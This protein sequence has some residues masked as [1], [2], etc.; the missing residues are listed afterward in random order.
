M[1]CDTMQ[2]NATNRQRQWTMARAQRAFQA[3]S[4]FGYVVEDILQQLFEQWMETMLACLPKERL[5]LCKRP[6]YKAGNGVKVTSYIPF[7]ERDVTHIRTIYSGTITA[8]LRLT[9]KQDK[10]VHNQR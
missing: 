8:A 6:L 5:M 7:K 9:A 3:A 4:V 1:T 2:V 10:R